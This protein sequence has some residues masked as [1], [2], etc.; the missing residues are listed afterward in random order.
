[1]GAD[2]KRKQYDGRLKSW[3]RLKAEKAV[4]EKQ[5]I[6]IQLG[7][8]TDFSDCIMFG[9]DVT[10]EIVV[11]SKQHGIRWGLS[12]KYLHSKYLLDKLTENFNNIYN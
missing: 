4:D 7:D 5:P 10:G 6:G 2:F 8:P 12:A 9:D 3:N 11:N 1:M